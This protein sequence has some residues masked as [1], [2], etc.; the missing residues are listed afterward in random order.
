MCNFILFLYYLTFRK[1]IIN[2]FNTFLTSESKEYS[3]SL[4][5][6]DTASSRTRTKVWYWYVSW[7]LK[8]SSCFLTFSYS[9]GKADQQILLL[10]RCLVE[11]QIRNGGASRSIP[12]NA[13]YKSDGSGD[14]DPRARMDCPFQR[15]ARSRVW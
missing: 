1:Y 6:A 4:Q 9:R 8:S 2:K 13:D 3:I 7:S 5:N 10:S 11:E 15:W 14:N 12:N